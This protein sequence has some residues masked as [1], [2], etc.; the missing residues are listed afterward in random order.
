MT[1]PS[2]PGGTRPTPSTPVLLLRTARAEWLRLR[3]VRSTWLVAAT[4]VLAIAGF[5]LLIG[6][7]S[8]GEG[9]TDPGETAWTP[10]GILGIL[11]MLVLLA[12]AAAS[13]TA[14]FGTGGIVPTLQWTPRRGVLLAARTAVIVV[15]TVAL[16]LLVALLAAALVSGLAPALGLPWEEGRRTLGALA[17]VYALGAAIAVGL[18]LLL[19]ST[20][21]A[22]VSVLG[23]M[24]VLPLLLGNLPFDWAQDIARLMPGMSALELVVDGG[25]PGVTT[26][27][28]RLNLAA[29]AAAALLLGGGRLLQS[30]AN[31]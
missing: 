4:A 12:L 7:D 19:R 18:G 2:P 17:S 11:C 27:S 6:L 3:T 22:V 30:D 10:V 13:T 25:L 21:A 14:D 24:M 15:F 31:R 23:V 8:R 1:S 5:S 20:A 16:G 9:Q 29:W 26:T 28:A